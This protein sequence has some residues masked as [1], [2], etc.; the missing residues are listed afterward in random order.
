MGD[1]D[2]RCHP[3]GGAAVKLVA[4]AIR[5]PRWF[6]DHL[7]IAGQLLLGRHNSRSLDNALKAADYRHGVNYHR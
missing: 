7:R 5:H 6:V 1:V 2:R 4:T 3:G